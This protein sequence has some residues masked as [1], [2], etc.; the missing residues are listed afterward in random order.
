MQ[1]H[2]AN[3]VTA[4]PVCLPAADE[5]SDDT[6]FILAEPQTPG[7]QL[8]NS[9]ILA[10]LESHLSY[11]T[12]SQ[13]VDIINLLQCYPTLFADVPGTTNVL[14]HDIDVGTFAPIKQHP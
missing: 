4:V 1:H 14:F 2:Q 12:E 7:F 10:N 6:D 3:I 9:T 8:N 11:L 13:R 5:V